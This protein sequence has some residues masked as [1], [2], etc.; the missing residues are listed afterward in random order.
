MSLRIEHAILHGEPHTI[1]VEGG[2]ISRIEAERSREGT[3]PPANRVI[4]AGGLHLFPSLRNG[5]THVAMVLLRGYGEDL[6][7]MEWLQTRIWPAEGRMTPEDVYRGARLGMLEMIRGGTTFLNEMYWPRE[8]IVRA[9]RE[10]GLRALVA[11]PLMDIGDPAFLGA[12]K[13][14]MTE[15]LEEA[16]TSDPSGLVGLTLAPHAIYTVSIP[17]LEWIAGMASD[18]GLL[19][20]TH[21]SETGGEVERCLAEHGVRPAHLLARVGL[22][23]PHLVAAHGQF[24]D[25]SEL[26]L[27]GSAG[28]TIVTNPVSNLKLATGG[29][30]PWR[31]ARAAGV[32]VVIGTDGAASNNNL[33]LLE[34]LKVAALLEKHRTADATVLNAREALAMA[35]TEA[36]QAFG[37]GTGRVEEGAPADLIL[38]DLSAAATQPIHD[39]VSTLLYAANA[40]HVHTTICDGKVLMYD[41]KVEVCDDEEVLR[42]A[43]E[44]ARRI[45][46]A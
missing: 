15:A 18:H 7:L 1:L 43:A 42:E 16:R 30:F 40:S 32:R 44:S 14:A 24:L 38:V 33:D 12:M 4:D 3:P 5:H 41:R 22:V 10:M 28:A 45:A 39:P 23:G 6:P 31:E 26:E 17:D 46:G 29:I 35:T 25:P 37:L 21:L 34:E 11:A 8:P 20:H 9:A 19:V 36:A 27:L 13:G 2:T